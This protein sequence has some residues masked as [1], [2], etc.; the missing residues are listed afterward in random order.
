MT[1]MKIERLPEGERA[2]KDVDCIH[3][4]AAGDGTFLL[5]GSAL[6]REP[7][8]DDPQSVAI[9]GS[10]PYPSYE[11]AEDAGMAWA[12]GLGVELLYVSRS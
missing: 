12:A 8:V 3:I 6:T 10:E 1:E 11:A 2:A 4:E 9:V 5:V 7:E